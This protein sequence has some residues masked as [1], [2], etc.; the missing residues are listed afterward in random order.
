MLNQNHV[1]VIIPA[2]NEEQ[3]I[4]K[5]IG[6][7][8]NCVDQILV[9]D[10]D[11]QDATAELAEQAGAKVIRESR[12]GYGMACLTGIRESGKTDILAF[13]DGGYSDYPEQLED[14]I[15][16]V[17]NNRCDLAIGCRQVDSSKPR[18]RFRHQQWGTK[19]VCLTIQLLHGF[20]FEDLGPMRCIKE[21]SLIH[22]NMEDR[23]FGW[24]VEMQLKAAKAGFTILQI[25]VDYRKRLG[26]SKISGTLKGSLMAGYKMFYWIIRLAISQIFRNRH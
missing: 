4:A 18:G 21:S 14:L 2:L 9:V 12:K 24:T 11:S 17:A 3:S 15:E 7:I 20:R 5:V 8:P 26:K 10:N 25:P 19:L 6:E 13:V 1:T 16:S 23:D 22:L